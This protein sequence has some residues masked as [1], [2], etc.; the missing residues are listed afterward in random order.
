[1]KI[2]R[3]IFYILEQYK[4]NIYDPNT[5][6]K[7]L[8]MLPKSM[9]ILF[10]STWIMSSWSDNSRGQI[11]PFSIFIRLIA[12]HRLMRNHSFLNKR[13]N[14]NYMT[15]AS[16]KKKTELQYWKNMSS[17]LKGPYANLHDD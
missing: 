14:I 10:Y 11:I 17:L 8:P 5:I 16:K 13:N 4:N 6:L 1:M 9:P 2:A 3:A 7:Q 15:G 12:M